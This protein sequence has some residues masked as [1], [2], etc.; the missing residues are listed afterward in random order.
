MRYMMLF[1]S[2]AIFWRAGRSGAAR[3]PAATHLIMLGLF[4]ILLLLF[5]W[6]GTEKDRLAYSVAVRRWPSLGRLRKQL[7]RVCNLVWSRV[8][9]QSAYRRGCASR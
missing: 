8:A 7:W 2:L 9:I 4:P 3:R 6:K 5:S 1:L